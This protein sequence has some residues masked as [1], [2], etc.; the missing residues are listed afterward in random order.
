MVNSDVK[1]C[2]GVVLKRYRLLSG[3]TQQNLADLSECHV[4]YIGTL[5]RGKIDPGVGKVLKVLGVLGVDVSEFF[6]EVLSGK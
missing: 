6:S 2:I 5:E 4:N 3:L 1:K